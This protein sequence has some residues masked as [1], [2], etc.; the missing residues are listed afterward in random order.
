[1]KYASSEERNAENM[2]NVVKIAK[3][4]VK[5]GTNANTLVNVRLAAT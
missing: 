2:G 5:I 1:M 3:A 4:M